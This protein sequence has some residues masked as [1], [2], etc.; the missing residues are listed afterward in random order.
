MDFSRTK[1][2]IGKIWAA[3]S[4]DRCSTR[5]PS[6]S[7]KR[8]TPHSLEHDLIRWHRHLSELPELLHRNFQEYWK[9]LSTRAP[10]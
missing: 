1:H 4:W 7:R 3:R 9:G 2:Q 5:L 10:F 6:V 8:P